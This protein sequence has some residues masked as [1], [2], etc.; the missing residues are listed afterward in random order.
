MVLVHDNDLAQLDGVENSESDIVSSDDDGLAWLDETNTLFS[1]DLDGVDNQKEIDAF[2]DDL[3]GADNSK[4]IIPFSGSLDG[5]DD[6]ESDSAYSVDRVDD[7]ED[8]VS[9]V[10]LVRQCY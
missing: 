6:S 9:G 1:D 7:S 8:T 4:R 5:G 2:S 10:Y 3:D